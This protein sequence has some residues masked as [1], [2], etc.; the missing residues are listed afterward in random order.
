MSGTPYLHQMEKPGYYNTLMPYLIVKDALGLMDFLKNI[1]GAEEKM[2]H[3]GDDGK[4]M[5]GEMLIRESTVMISE[6]SDTWPTQTAGMFIYVDNVDECYRNALAAGATSV[7][8]IRD[9]EYGR[10]GGIQDPSGNVWWIT[11]G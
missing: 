4:L 8:E 6:A 1:F 9:Q 10:S 7:L 2:K 11:Q 5:H 3:L